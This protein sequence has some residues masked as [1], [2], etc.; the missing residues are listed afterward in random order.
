MERESEKWVLDALLKTGGWDVLHPESKP[1]WETLGYAHGDIES[2]FGRIRSGSMLPKAWATRAQEVERLARHAESEGY[3]L[4]ARD[5]YLRASL[6]YGRAQ[7]SFYRDAPIKS[8]YHARL[9]DCFE[10]VIR[11]TPERIERVRIGDVYATLHLPAGRAP[12]SLPALILIPGMDMVKEEWTRPSLSLFLPRGFA[13]LALDGPGQGESL[14]HGLKV[15]LTNYDDAGKAAYEFLAGHPEI[16]PKRIALLGVSMG[17]YWGCRIAATEPRLACAATGLACYGKKHIIFRQAQPNFRAN[18]KYMAGL[19]DDAEFDRLADAMV[20]TDLMPQIRM[21][22]LMAQAE[23]DELND[24]EETYA[25]YDQVKSP[26][27][28]WVYEDQF[29]PMGGVSGEFYGS[30]ADWVTAR[31]QGAPIPSGSRQMYIR[32]DGTVRHGDAHPDW[33]TP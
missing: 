31:L 14:L 25:V 3:L 22:L 26:K 28:L 15:N 4:T 5:L 12:G 10:Q 2:V 30:A 8:A 6:L 33:W 23:F 1:Y 20:L 18:F 21:P 13:T 17:S 19:E 11:L 24:L 7:Y 9:V 27:E 32:T 29:H 16:D